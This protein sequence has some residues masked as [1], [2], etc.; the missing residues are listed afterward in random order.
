M[1][2]VLIAIVVLAL[3]VGAVFFFDS[4]VIENATHSGQTKVA[5]VW[6]DED[7]IAKYDFGFGK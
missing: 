3:L 6:V 7:E 1:K 5:G 4:D 2:N